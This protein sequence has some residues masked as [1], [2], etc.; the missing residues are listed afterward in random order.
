MFLRV[1]FDMR[2]YIVLGYTTEQIIALKA[3]HEADQDRAEI[4]YN[5]EQIR[6]A[7]QAEASAKYYAEKETNGK[8]CLCCG[9]KLSVA[10]TSGYC[11]KHVA[12]ATLTKEVKTPK[13]KYVTK[14]YYGVKGDDLLDHTYYQGGSVGNGKRS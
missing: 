11:R 9:A 7:Y 6:L 1:K 4:E 12:K 10:N 13:I 8:S 14:T 3:E 5:R 2:K